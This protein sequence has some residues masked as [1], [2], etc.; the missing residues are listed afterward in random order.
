MLIGQY[1]IL[2]HSLPQ[3]LILESEKLT[4]LSR[5]SKLSF[6]H[7]DSDWNENKKSI[8]YYELSNNKA[9]H[10]SN[11][12]IFL[13]RGLEDTLVSSYFQATK[14]DI[15]FNGTISEFVRD[16][17]FGA[18][19]ILQ[20]NQ[21]WIKNRTTPNKFMLLS[22]EEIHDNTNQALIDVLSFMGASIDSK[23]VEQ[24]V[25]KCSFTNMKRA[26]EKNTYNSFRLQP[27]DIKDQESFKIRK[28]TVGGYTDYLSANDITYINQIKEEMK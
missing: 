23:L 20:F 10:K 11:N 7:E 15:G 17:R 8:P 19:K 1:L 24:A 21:I 4:Q 16:D 28:G 25:E 9:T 2:K 26:E 12:I 6:T 5:L 14:R 3:E 18:K 22:Y 13:H 27:G